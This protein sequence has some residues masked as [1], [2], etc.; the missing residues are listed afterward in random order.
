MFQGG[1]TVAFEQANP[2]QDEA[3]DLAPI[4]YRYRKWNLGDGIELVA[5]CEIDGVKDYRG[6]NKFFTT[7]ALTEH[8]S[9]ITSWR[10]KLDSQRGAVLA[11]ELKNN[12][13]KLARWILES[14]LAGADN[15]VLGYALCISYYSLPSLL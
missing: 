12:S 8:D 7:H 15:L 9:K 10:Q 5:R 6:E 14:I 13:S 11:T 2:F 3:E 1:D 4:G